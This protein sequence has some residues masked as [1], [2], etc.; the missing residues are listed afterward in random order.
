MFHPRTPS[1]ELLSPCLREPV[2]IGEGEDG[3]LQETFNKGAGQAA[4]V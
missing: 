3:R 1:E 2:L 4:E